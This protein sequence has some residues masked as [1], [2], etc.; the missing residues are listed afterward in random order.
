MSSETLFRVWRNPAAGWKVRGSAAMGF[1]E[2]V[3]HQT[4]SRHASWKA[5]GVP[6]R[7]EEAGAFWPGCDLTLLRS[8]A[9]S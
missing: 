2:R 9:M 1:G 6:S 8:A 3:E 5:A 4:E 7:L